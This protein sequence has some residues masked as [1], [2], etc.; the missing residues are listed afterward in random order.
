M[1]YRYDEA[2]T[3]AG[4]TWHRRLDDGKSQVEYEYGQ[5]ATKWQGVPPEIKELEDVLAFALA[6]L[7][8][9]EP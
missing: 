4:D 7:E 6:K 1:L 3:F 2:G 5:R 8:A 9:S